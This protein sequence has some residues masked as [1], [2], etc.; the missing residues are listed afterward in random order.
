MTAA[1]RYIHPSN[2]VT[3]L[4]L[5]AGLLASRLNH[6][7]GQGQSDGQDRDRPRELDHRGHPSRGQLISGAAP[8]GLGAPG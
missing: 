7:A 6:G 2:A 1:A 8:T 4:S 5:L 3:Y